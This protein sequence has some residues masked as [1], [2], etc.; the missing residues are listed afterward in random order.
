MEEIAEGRGRRGY[1]VAW[2][3]Y[4]DCHLS[5]RGSHVRC[6]CRAPGAFHI[7]T[8]SFLRSGGALGGPRQPMSDRPD[9]ALGVRG[10][11]RTSRVRSR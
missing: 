1:V 7:A 2:R 4:G 11:V 5:A 9:D 3:R 8:Q 10:D 6:R